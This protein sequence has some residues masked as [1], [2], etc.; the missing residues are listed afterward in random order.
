MFRILIRVQIKSAVLQTSS[1][2][3]V[4][5]LPARPDAKENNYEQNNYIILT[6]MT[7]LEH[8]VGTIIKSYHVR[9]YDNE[10]ESLI[11]N[12]Y[13]HRIKEVSA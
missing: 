4:S 7:F 5:E 13:K 2:L 6:I 8:N 1:S 10:M 11:C 3:P 12:G 9:K